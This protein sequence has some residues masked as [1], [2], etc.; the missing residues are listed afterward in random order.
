TTILEEFLRT[1]EYFL[2]QGLFTLW[3][4][5]SGFVMAVALGLL[6]AV[7]INYSV[8]LETT[9]FT[10]LV[11]LNSVPKVALAP[12]FIIW[13]GTGAEPK[14]T[15]ALTIAIFPIVIDF[16]LGLRSAD[17]QLLAVVRAA[18]ATAAQIFLKVRFPSA[19]PSM[20]AGMKV[21]ISLALIGAIVGEFV[22]GE[23]GLG[24]VILLAQGQF[25]TARMFVAVIMLGL[26][27]AILFYA[28]DFAERLA[29]PWHVSQRGGH[30][31][32]SA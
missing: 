24:Q 16:V 14:I 10:L 12:V 17:P 22:A 2:N 19:L 26:L 32:H 15:I 31:G 23:T 29:I 18:R 21:G 11:A 20:F 3:T 28:V 30:A 6:L 4:T 25:Q 8:F 27:G 13:M 9:I 1:P 7:A 5:A